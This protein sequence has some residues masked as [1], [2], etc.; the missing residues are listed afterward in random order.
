MTPT[1]RMKPLV[2]LLALA[3]LRILVGAQEAT[4]GPLYHEAVREFTSMKTTIYQHKT[5]VDREAGSYKYDCVHFVSY[6]MRETAPQAWETILREMQIAKGRIPGPTSYQKFFARLLEAPQA[7]WEPVRRAAELRPG[8][9]VSWQY[10]TARASGHAVI[11]AGLPQQAAD[12]SWKVKVYD[13]TST[14]HAEDSRPDD[15]RAQVY[16][17][18]GRRSGLGHGVMAFSVDT[19]T[20]ALTGYRWTPKGKIILCP[21]GAGRPLR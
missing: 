6:A 17:I 3:G 7:G 5:E 15:P 2:I 20:G 21:I 4:T 14:P 18:T 10:K 13:A 9:V 16:D 1:L 19:T 12:G 8:D 11:I